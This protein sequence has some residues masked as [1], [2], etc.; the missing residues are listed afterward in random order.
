V[1]QLEN[2]L[3]VIKEM[4]C[5]PETEVEW[6]VLGLLENGRSQSS[7]YDIKNSPVA[8]YMIKSMGFKE[9]RRLMTLAKEFFKQAD[10]AREGSDLAW[11][12]GNEVRQSEEFLKGLKAA[13][14][15][16]A[17]CDRSVIE[18]ITNGVLLVFE[19]RKE[20]M[21]GAKAQAECPVTS[22]SQP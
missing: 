7:S 11:K 5:P 22:A 8:T 6:E 1:A 19:S 15:F 13:E 9:S 12:E 3:P 2:F 10:A 18:T 21:R 4:P 16:L 20:A 14:A 17:A